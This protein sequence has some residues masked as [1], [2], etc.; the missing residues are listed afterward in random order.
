MKA[1]HFTGGLYIDITVVKHG[2]DKAFDFACDIL[3]AI[4]AEFGHGAIK[5]ACLIDIEDAFIRYDKNIK[6]IFHEC[7]K[8]E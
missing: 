2:L 5:E 6:P 7:L 1:F 8:E 3:C 4:E